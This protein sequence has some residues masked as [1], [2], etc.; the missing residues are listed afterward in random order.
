LFFVSVTGV[1]I[2]ID[3]LIFSGVEGIHLLGDSN[4]VTITNCHF[5]ATAYST[6]GYGILLD[7]GTGY[8]VQN[9]SFIGYYAAIDAATVSVLSLV[10]EGNTFIAPNYAA[11]NFNGEFLNISANKVPLLPSFFDN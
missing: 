2:T 6:S 1:D 3:G 9:N 5:E 10:V 11:V 8:V 7:G 4:T